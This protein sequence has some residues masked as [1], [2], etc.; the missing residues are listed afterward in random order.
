MEQELNQRNGK[1]S[2]HTQTLKPSMNTMLLCA[3]SKASLDAMS[4]KKP[5]ATRK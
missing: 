4:A 1:H 2:A 3:L 5:A